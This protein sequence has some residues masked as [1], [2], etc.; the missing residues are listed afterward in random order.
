RRSAGLLA[1]YLDAYLAR[2]RRR[3]RR[4]TPGGFWQSLQYHFDAH[5]T[6]RLL[7]RVAR[8]AAQRTPPMTRV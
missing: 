2:T 8:G 5:D 3:G 1:V 4:P 6:R 7:V